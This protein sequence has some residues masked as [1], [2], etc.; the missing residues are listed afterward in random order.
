LAA[1]RKKGWVPGSPLSL[2]YQNPERR[3]LLWLFL[4]AS[5]SAGALKFLGTAL[6]ALQNLGLRQASRRFQ[7]LLLKDDRLEWKLKRGTA[8]AALKTMDELRSASGKS[9]LHLA[10][11]KMDQAVRK[12][13]VLPQDRLLICSDGL[14]T[15]DSAASLESEKRRFQGLLKKMVQRFHSSAWVHPVPKRGMRRWIPDLADSSKIQLIEIG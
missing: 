13:G 14:F 7:V 8:G 3:P 9:R 10:L 4:D 11:E 6:M 12:A 5:R 2:R 15:P 1:S